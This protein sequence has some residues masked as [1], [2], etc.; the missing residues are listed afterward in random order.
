[1]IIFRV[2]YTLFVSIC[3]EAMTQK[4]LIAKP[5]LNVN[6]WGLQYEFFHGERASFFRI[7][8]F[9]GDGQDVYAFSCLQCVAQRFFFFAYL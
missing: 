6:N 5:A 9:H 8:I 1:M 4:F 7:M 3:K 2:K